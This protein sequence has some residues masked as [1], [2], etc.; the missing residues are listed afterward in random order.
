MGHQRS[1]IARFG[2]DRGG[3]VALIFAL[4][5]LMLCFTAG[6]AID[7]SRAYSIS[8]KLASI[9]DSAA[10]AG[11][12]LLD[13]DA[14]TDAQVRAKALAYFNAHLTGLEVP[15]ITLTDLVVTPDRSNSSVTVTVNVTMPTAFGHVAGITSFDFSK[16]STVIY[17]MKKIELA[18][19]LDVTGSM[20]D[21]PAAGGRIKIDDLKDAAKDVID[22]L[23]SES[24][25]EAS[26]RIGLVPWSSAVNP[27][28]IGAV[29]T[30]YAGYSGCTIERAGAAVSDSSPTMGNPLLRYDAPYVSDPTSGCP[31]QP[32]APL[33]GKSARD[34]LRGSVDSIS[35]SG[36]TAGHIGA[37]WGWYLLAPDWSSLYATASQPGPYGDANISKNLVLMTDGKFN[38]AYVGGNA[39]GSAGAET[40]S[41]NLFR[42]TCDAMKAKGITIYTIGFDLGTDVTAMPYAKLR[43]CASNASNFFAA[44]NGGDLRNAFR[45]IA[46]RLNTI[47]IV[48]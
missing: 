36:W 30:G 14:A 9:L 25:S 16:S 41:Y 28:S 42:Q 17:R 22:T 39:Q 23:F 15:G 37:Q 31:S 33:V 26:V 3:A 44:V 11:A 34:T 18:M 40:E 5:L 12:K 46:E 7:G 19:A 20:G 6:L 8:N 27:G 21:A 10:L 1:S 35:T 2:R 13:E 32:V 4:S 38:A 24:P 43:E 48:N 45:Q 29:A 47:R